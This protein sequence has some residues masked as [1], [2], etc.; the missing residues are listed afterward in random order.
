MN[1]IVNKHIFAL[2]RLEKET[3]KKKEAQEEYYEKPT[4]KN[5]IKKFDAEEN[6]NNLIN[7]LNQEKQGE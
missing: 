7:Y 2:I 1:Q 4:R 6:L 3:K 5:R